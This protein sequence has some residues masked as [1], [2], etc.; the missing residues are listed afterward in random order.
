M[1]ERNTENSWQK[2]K[3]RLFGPEPDMRQGRRSPRLPRA[4]RTPLQHL[5]LLVWGR[6]ELASMQRMPENIGIDI[7]LLCAEDLAVEFCARFG[8]TA[9]QPKGQG[10]APILWALTLP[11]LVL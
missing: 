4:P 3:I 8:G 5:Q 1:R 11:G 9:K 10:C 6:A 2:A 7:L